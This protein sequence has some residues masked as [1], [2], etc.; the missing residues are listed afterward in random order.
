MLHVR[1][2]VQDRRQTLGD[3]CQEV[4]PDDHDRDAGRA[5]VLLGARVKQPVR[6]HIE[7]TGEQVGGGVGHQGHAVGD[8]RRGR[9]LDPLDR[10]VRRDVRIRGGRG[11][12]SRQ[13]IGPGHPHEPGFLAAPRRADRAFLRRLGDRLL[14]P[15]P[16]HHVVGHRVGSAQEVHRA[17]REL[18]RRATLTEQ[19]PMVRGHGQEFP[20]VGLGLLDD[21]RE[22]RAAVRDLQRRCAD[23]RKRHQLALRLFEHRER[24][25]ARSRSEVEH[26][27]RHRVA[28]ATGRAPFSPGPAAA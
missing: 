8:R 5:G 2:V 4:V 17:H 24:Q 19:D 18:H 13:L 15:R 28:K 9:E 23:P 22:P 25:R 20:E 27:F 21:G 26:A 10:L 12:R 1:P 14:T 3:E 7:P 16:G 6:A 11:E